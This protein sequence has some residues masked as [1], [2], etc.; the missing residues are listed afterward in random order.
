M[1]DTN[2]VPEVF[3]DVS[4]P[5]AS[6]LYQQIYSMLLLL[7]L[8]P[9]FQTSDVND[10]PKFINTI[11]AR[12]SADYDGGEIEDGLRAVHYALREGA[13]MFRRN[14]CQVDEN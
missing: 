3:M 9:A 7:N 5:R 10:L 8:L 13:A 6:L 1:T 4:D 11:T 14:Y 2:T 12:L